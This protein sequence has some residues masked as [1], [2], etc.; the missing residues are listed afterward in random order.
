LR[1]SNLLFVLAANRRPGRLVRRDVAGRFDCV[2]G[3]VPESALLAL[4]YALL[5]G[6]GANPVARG[7]ADQRQGQQ[8]RNEECAKAEN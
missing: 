4:V 1:I 3:A 7:R 8:Q 6:E 2:G 5:S